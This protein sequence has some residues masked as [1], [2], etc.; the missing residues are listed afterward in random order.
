MLPVLRT[1][2]Y[3]L[4][5]RRDKSHTEFMQ[6]YYR[7]FRTLIAYIKEHYA[8]GITW[9]NKDGIDATAALAEIKSGSKARSSVGGASSPPP[10]PPLP[11]FDNVG[12]P[13]PPP[14]PPTNGTGKGGDMT[15]IF[16]QLNQGSSVTAGLRKVDKSEMTHK[17]PA[18][19]AGSAVPERSN[20]QSSETSRGKSPVPSKRPKPESMRQKKPPKKELDGNKW[21]IENFENT[22]Y[23]PIEIDAQP[24]HSILI[25]KCSKCV[26][27]VTGKANAISIDNSSGLSILVDSLISSLD[28]IKSQKF[29]VQVDGVLPT[30]LLDQVDGA[31]IYL[32]KQSMGTGVFTSKSSSI[33]IVLPP[34]DEREGDDK[35]VALPEQIRTYIK[36]GA[37]VSEIVEH[38]G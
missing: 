13:P 6:A 31:Q 2:F 18:L 32:S 23:E 7:I 19:R 29:Q 27:K 34:S 3:M 22:G 24:S 15:A 25:T 36:N 28:V 21:L 16:D 33:N 10:P 1:G 5:I 38:A 30:V 26:I 11:T 4:T 37:V 14:P 12:G 35:E 20:S 17:N 9:N 8:T